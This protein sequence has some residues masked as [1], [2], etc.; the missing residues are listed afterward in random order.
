VVWLEMAGLHLYCRWGGRTA[1]SKRL[2]IW[3]MHSSYSSSCL[4]IGIFNLIVQDPPVETA[5]I[6]R[7]DALQG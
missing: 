5:L 3:I 7:F 6:V 4:L 1:L 2:S